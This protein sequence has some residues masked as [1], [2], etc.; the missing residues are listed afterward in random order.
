MQH[1]LIVCGVYEDKLS[2]TS[3]ENN[4]TFAQ[5]I[6]S[7]Q[8]TL[9]AELTNAQ[10]ISLQNN[11]VKNEG[12]NCIVNDDSPVEIITGVYVSIYENIV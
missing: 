6:N 2:Y 3:L 10:I 8:D 5:C 11:I 4:L 1:T 9:D 7:I 12:A